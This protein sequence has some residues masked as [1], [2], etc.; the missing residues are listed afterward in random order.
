MSDSPFALRLSQAAYWSACPGFV[1]MNQTGQAAVIEAAGDNSIREEGTAM[2]WC[3]E[4]L[5]DPYGTPVTV[6]DVAPNGVVITDE[7]YDGATF[8]LNVLNTYGDSSIMAW[9]VEELLA[10]PSIHPQ[11]G[12]TPDAFGLD[13]FKS[14]IVLVDLKGGF[15]NVEVFPNWQ[16]IGYV[17]AIWDTW[18]DYVT[19]DTELELCIVQPRSFHRDGPV[20]TKT[21]LIRDIE[22][23]IAKLSVAAH[24][25]Y[26]DGAQCIAGPQ[27]DDC[28][29]RTSC[30]TC[31]DAGMRALEVSGDSY[32]H[33]LGVVALDYE[34]QRIESA[35]QILDALLTGYQAQAEH[36]M[37]R[38][39]QFP[40]FGLET[41][42]GRL[43][44]KDDA[45]EAAAIAVADLVG[46]NIRK[47]A[48]AITPLQAMK[49]LP[50]EYVEKY[51]QRKRGELKLARFDSN[52][53]VKAFSHLAIKKD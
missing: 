17:C 18:P 14:R 42:I 44:W 7:L 16:L 23:Y 35:I 31:H 6:G 39:V 50:K 3:A 49:I 11:C 15:R 36:M 8:Y 4:R 9:H 40:H 21:M 51:A 22:P 25:A 48:R 28:A 26:G 46:A 34:M 33:D 13:L 41:G 47:P 43:G 45:A 12:G 20:R 2:H 5:Q 38:G 52:A 30:V 37:R 53:A 24:R 32:V 29:A 10:A 19:P 1:R 27:C